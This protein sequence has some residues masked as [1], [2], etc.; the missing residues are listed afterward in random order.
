[1]HEHDQEPVPGLPQELPD[2]ERILWQGRSEASSLAVSTLHLKKLAAYFVALLALRLVFKLNDGVTLAEAISGSLGLVVLAV[3]AIGL[4]AYYARRAAAASMFTI[5]D[6][7]IVLRCGV[8][9]SVTVNLPYTIIDSAELRLHKDGSG[10]ISIRTDRRSRASYI[11]L[12]PMVKPFR[13]FNVQPVLRGLKSAESVAETL[14]NALAAHEL[15]AQ[16]NNAAPVEDTRRESRD[17]RTRRR[18]WTVYPPLA[19]AASLVVFAIVAVSAYQLSNSG[20]EQAPLESAIASVD[21]RFE[22]QDDGSVAVIDASDGSLIDT[23]QPGTNGFVRGALR[24]LARERRASGIGAEEPFSILRT[25]SGQV[26]L[27]DPATGRLIDLRAFGPTNRDAFGR[28]L[29]ISANDQIADESSSETG[30][31][32]IGVTAMALTQQEIEK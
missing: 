2:G 10:D 27:H 16:Q 22:D 9:V 28:F 19:G 14:A 31:A 3:V 12:W 5:T 17:A 13:W 15:A 25:A 24:S 26:V 20:A 1:M 32:D 18:G 23:L 11:L 7:R 30:N 29:T 21:L 8:A 4:L 6:R